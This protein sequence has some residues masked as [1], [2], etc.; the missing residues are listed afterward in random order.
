MRFTVAVALFAGL[1][2]A[3]KIESDYAIW[4]SVAPPPPMWDVVK[5]GAHGFQDLNVE[6]AM[7]LNPSNAG[8]WPIAPVVTTSWDKVLEKPPYWAKQDWERVVKKGNSPYNDK[9]VEK[10]MQ[11]KG[12]PIRVPSEG[13]KDKADAAEAKASEIIASENKA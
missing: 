4:H 1:S 6:K 8:E 13:A 9:Q 2:Q 11:L 10:A 3:I 5:R 12:E 7:K